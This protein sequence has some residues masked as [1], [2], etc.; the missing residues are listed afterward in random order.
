MAP[1]EAANACAR[2]RNVSASTNASNRSSLTRPRRE[3]HV[4]DTEERVG[5]G[6]GTAALGLLPADAESVHAQFDRVIEALTE[7]LPQI[8]VHLA[9]ARDDILGFTEFPKAISRQI[10]SETRKN[11]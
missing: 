3:S 1:Q 4:G 2:W 6:E 11:G 7:K 8:A 5:L 10:W 9:D